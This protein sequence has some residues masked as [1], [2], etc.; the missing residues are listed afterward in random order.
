MSMMPCIQ[1]R[2]LLG[3]ALLV[4]CA[5]C[6][7]SDGVDYSHTSYE[8]CVVD[9]RGLEYEP[10]MSA[11]GRLDT[12]EVQLL[13]IS[14]APPDVGASEWLVTVTDLV[15]GEPREGCALTASTWMPDHGH[16]GPEGSSNEEL[17]PGRYRLEGLRYLM[18]GYWETSIEIE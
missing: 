18:A 7:D 1:I 4:L 15:S 14:P 12:Y 13:S 6:G 9:G 16:G 5:A 17:E 3:S 2:L 11:I 10:G 8:Y